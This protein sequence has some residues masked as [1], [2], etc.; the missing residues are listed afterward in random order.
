MEG[1]VKIWEVGEEEEQSGSNC[2]S[3]VCVL[4]LHSVKCE[5]TVSVSHDCIILQRL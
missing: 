5:V 2:S 1:F 4:H 3:V